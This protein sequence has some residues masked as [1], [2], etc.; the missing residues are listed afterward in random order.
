MADLTTIEVR[1]VRASEWRAL[2]DVRLRALADA[3]YAFASTYDREA[4]WPDGEWQSWAARAEA[5]ESQRTVVAVRDRQ[6]VGMSFAVLGEDGVTN[7]YGVWVD[8]A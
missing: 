4:A 7:L 8:P 1:V 6:W 3:P 2:R 5:D